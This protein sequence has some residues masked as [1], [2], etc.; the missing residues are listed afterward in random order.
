MRK[1]TSADVEFLNMITPRVGPANALSILK[2]A[3]NNAFIEM[4]KELGLTESKINEIM[5]KHL[6]KIAQKVQ[7]LPVRSPIQFNKG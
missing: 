6:T 7:N 2:D 5:D 1:N 3:K 4:F